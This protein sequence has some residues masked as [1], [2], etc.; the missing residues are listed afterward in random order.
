MRVR[1]TSSKGYHEC[2]L[3]YA[4]VHYLG[5]TPTWKIEDALQ[6]HKKPVINGWRVEVIK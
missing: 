4:R 2:G 6:Q 1:L 5:R 3:S